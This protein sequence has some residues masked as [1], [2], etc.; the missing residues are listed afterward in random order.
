MFMRETLKFII[1]Q[2]LMTFSLYMVTFPLFLTNC[3]RLNNQKHT[4]QLEVS[5]WVLFLFCPW[6]LFIACSNCKNSW[7]AYKI[8]FSIDAETQSFR[9]FRWWNYFNL[10]LCCI[11]AFYLF[12]ILLSSQQTN[13]VAYIFNWSV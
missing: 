9:I 6:E 4:S 8:R 13:N 12:H 5:F 10:N 1:W 7:M 2:V 11:F 3:T